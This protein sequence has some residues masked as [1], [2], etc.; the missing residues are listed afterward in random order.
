MV[1]GNECR[2]VHCGR[3]SN[4]SERVR[5]VEKYTGLLCGEFGH[6]VA[7]CLRVQEPAMDSFE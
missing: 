7:Q 5:G 4:W 3:W 1:S 2:Y 6:I